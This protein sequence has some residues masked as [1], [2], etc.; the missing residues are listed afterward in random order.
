MTSD[1][2]WLLNFIVQVQY[3]VFVSYLIDVFCK[4]SKIAKNNFVMQLF[5]FHT[6]TA[7]EREG[8]EKH[9]AYSV[10]EDNK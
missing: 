1:R 9:W 6:C 5:L 10:Y 2:L 4:V 7:W 3:F 8:G